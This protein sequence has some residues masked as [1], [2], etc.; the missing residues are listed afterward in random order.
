MVVPEIV[1]F[2]VV[3]GFLFVIGA[4]IHD[5]TKSVPPTENDPFAPKTFRRFVYVLITTLLLI[6]FVALAVFLI[7]FPSAF[8]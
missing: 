5:W 1:Y 3:V 2:L 7:F 4:L 6:A 8:S